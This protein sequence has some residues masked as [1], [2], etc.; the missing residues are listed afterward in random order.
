MSDLDD[1][2]EA[3]NRHISNSLSIGH[4]QPLHIVKGEMQYL[5]SND[6]TRYLDLVKQ[7]L[8]CK[9]LSSKSGCSR[10]KTNGNS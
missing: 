9:S 7:R 6:G 2:L 5:F 8:S 4:G 3:R 10:S 1:L